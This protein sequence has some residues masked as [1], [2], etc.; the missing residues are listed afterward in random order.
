[1]FGYKADPSYKPRTIKIKKLSNTT[2]QKRLYYVLQRTTEKGSNGKTIYYAYYNIGCEVFLWGTDATALQQ[3]MIKNL[4]SLASE[5]FHYQTE[6]TIPLRS[7]FWPL[8]FEHQVGKTYF[9]KC[10]CS[11][12]CTDGKNILILDSYISELNV[13]V[14]DAL[15]NGTIHEKLAWSSI[16]NLQWTIL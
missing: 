10:T 6:R 2:P 16:D 1:M 4:T 3:E 12:G 14:Y 5:A 9:A 11:D 7:L 13:V 8:D 15:I